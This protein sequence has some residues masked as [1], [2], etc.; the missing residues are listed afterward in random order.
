MGSHATR[1]TVAFQQ[2]AVRLG[3]RD[4][5][6]TAALVLRCSPRSI[7]NWRV[8]FAVPLAEPETLP[9]VRCPRCRRPVQMT[10]GDPGRELDRRRTIES[11]LPACLPA[12]SR[13]A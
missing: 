9:S 13:L 3:D 4:G 12:R 7:A 11:H 5:D 1:Y 6:N 8:R 2:Y 10:E